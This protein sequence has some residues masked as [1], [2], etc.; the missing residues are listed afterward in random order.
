MK[1][2]RFVSL[3][4][5][6]IM[7]LTMMTTAVSASEMNASSVGASGTIGA[8]K[9]SVTNN[10]TLTLTGDGYMPDFDGEGIDIPWSDYETDITVTSVIIGSGIKN[11]CSYCF[12]SNEELTSIT[13]EPNSQLE[14]IDEFAFEYSEI[15]S[16]VLPDSLK[17][18]NENAFRRCSKLTSV[19]TNAEVVVNKYAFN[20][21]SRLVTVNMPNATLESYAFNNVQSLQN[22]TA[23]ILNNY[24]LF[25]ISSLRNINITSAESIGKYALY[26]CK[27]VKSISSKATSIG[28]KAFYNCSSIEH[29]NLPEV[30]SIGEYAFYG[31]SNLTVVELGKIEDIGKNAF[32]NCKK[33]KTVTG[34]KYLS[35][36]GDG[37]FGMDA[38]L[39]KLVTTNRLGYIGTKAFY[40]C[41]SLKGDINVDKVSYVGKYAFANCYN[42]SSTLVFKGVERIDYCA[43]LN[44]KKI[45]CNSLGSKITNLGSYAMLGCSSIKSLY[46]P[47]SCQS[48]GA[49]SLIK[50]VTVCSVSSTGSLSY[51]YNKNGA[52]INIYGDKGCAAQKYANKYKV[53]FYYAVKKIVLNKSSVTLLRNKTT[54]VAVK[55]ISPSNAKVK[56]LSF[57]S[58][59]NNI[60]TV[61]SK[62]IIKGISKGTCYIYAKAKDGSGRYAKVS[63]TVR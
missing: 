38:C 54:T 61:S 53:N 50:N 16:I 20:D 56:T 43:F 49:N 37:A 5:V 32:Y 52:K 59:N 9:W 8:I 2:K 46:I 25:N 19:S 41:K 12:E 55:S 34:T 60:A 47:S 31:L 27:N 62:G 51:K 63:V 3:M 26:G 7:S 36:I 13:F 40:N 48:I 44:C 15:N 14:S 18:I 22:V 21:C 57:T 29:V 1:V 23:G 10:G 45:K 58:S 35:S 4:M 11:I 42:L 33:L 28:D 17:T 39:S 30:L 6:M 24:A